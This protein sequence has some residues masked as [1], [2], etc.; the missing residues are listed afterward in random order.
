MPRVGKKM[1][2]NN[3]S[4]A[5]SQ[6]CSRL[7]FSAACASSTKLQKKCQN[8]CTFHGPP[9]CS[10]A[11]TSLGILEWA[12]ETRPRLQYSAN[13]LSRKTSAG[14]NKV[15]GSKKSQKKGQKWPGC[16]GSSWFIMVHPKSDSSTEGSC[17]PKPKKR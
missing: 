16:L 11:V 9:L 2:N 13:S 7:L 4:C 12:D 17:G 14:S 6:L 8:I 3:W 10:K 5:V 15:Q 1:K